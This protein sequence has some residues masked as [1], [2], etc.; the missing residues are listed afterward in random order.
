ML[1]MKKRFFVSMFSCFPMSLFSDN[2]QNM[3]TD[4]AYQLH[5]VL[6]TQVYYST[7]EF[8]FGD[9]IEKLADNQRKSKFECILALTKTALESISFM[10]FGV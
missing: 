5:K 8:V 9:C 10:V 7:I 4:A 2:I 1:P 3:E 6:H